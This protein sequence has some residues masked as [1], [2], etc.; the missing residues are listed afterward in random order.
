MLRLQTTDHYIKVCM[1]TWL[2]CEANVHAEYNRPAP[3]QEILR[4]CSE[5]AEACFAVVTKLVSNPDDLDTLALDCLLH[6]R[7]CSRE[8]AKYPGEEELQFCS[9]VSSICADSIKE[10][11]VLQLN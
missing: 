3:R 6:C 4:Q 2:L 7:E 5:C 11:A 10:I 8:C 1:K 9:V